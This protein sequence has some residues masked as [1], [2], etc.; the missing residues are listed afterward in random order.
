MS[1]LVCSD[2]ISDQA[3]SVCLLECGNLIKSHCGALPTSIVQSRATIFAPAL[4][5]ARAS[6][7]VIDL[8][9]PPLM[10]QI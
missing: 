7:T 9:A 1:L 5:L 4:N 6:S 10:T 2:N 3:Q 8:T